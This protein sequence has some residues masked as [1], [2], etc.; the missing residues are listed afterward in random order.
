MFNRKKLSAHKR[1]M[2]RNLSTLQRMT[3][4]RMTEAS[5]D[6]AAGTAA[7]R[8]NVSKLLMVSWIISLKEALPWKC[9]ARRVFPLCYV[10]CWHTELLCEQ[11]EHCSTASLRP[12]QS[13]G[14]A[15][16]CLPTG[17]FPVT[18][19]TLQMAIF[20]TERSLQVSLDHLSDSQYLGAKVQRYSKI[21]LEVTESMHFAMLRIAN[22][23]QGHRETFENGRAPTYGSS[24]FL[25]VSVFSK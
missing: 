4:D 22:H 10:S 17:E 19:Q 5:T 9:Y 12:V 15:F 2:G 24:L 13:T 23:L 18:N 21:I 7:V 6:Q 11:A 20:S 25:R 3:R 8:A 1:W 16:W 14:I